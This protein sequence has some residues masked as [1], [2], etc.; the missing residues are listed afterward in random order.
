MLEFIAK[1]PEGDE[2]KLRDL[3]P[4]DPETL[5]NKNLLFAD[6]AIQPKPNDR[7]LFGRG[8]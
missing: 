6:E 3:L 2:M 4:D 1:L 8:G 7:V 5:I